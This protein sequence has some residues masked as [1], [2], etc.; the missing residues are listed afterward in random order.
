MNKRVQL[1]VRNAAC[2][3]CRLCSQAE[4]SD[5]CVTADGPNDADVLVVSKNPGGKRYLEMLSDSLEQAGLNWNAV[6]HTGALK[7]R[8]WDIDPNKTDM[9]ACRKYLE[10]ELEYIKPSWVLALGNEALFAATGRSGI[11]NHRGKIYDH[12][13]GAKIFPT[14]SPASVM[15]NPGQQQGFLADLTFF[16]RMVK[17]DSTGSSELPTEIAYV[18]TKEQLKAVCELLALSTTVAVDIETSGHDEF[19]D[20]A[21]LISIA[22]T[23]LTETDDGITRKWVAAIPLGHISSPFRSSWQRVLEILCRYLKR[24]PKVLAH[25]G[26]FDFRWIKQ[27]GVKIDSTFDTMLAAHL[28]N[29]NRE[30]GLKP[31]ARMML[32]AEPWG[33]STKDLDSTPLD[34]VL[35]YNALDT[36]WTMHLYFPLREDLLKNERLA[37]LMSRLMMPASNA[38]VDVEAHGVWLDVERC[39]TQLARY[40]G[41]LMAVEKLLREHVPD[42]HPFITYRA[43]GDVKSDGIN[44]NP[45][46]FLRWWLFDH[47][48]LPVIARGKEKDNGDPGDPSVAEAVM[49]ELKGQHPVIDL[50]IERS[51]YYKA[52]NSFFYPYLEQRRSDGRV[53]TTFKLTG[54]VTGR[55]SSGKADADKVTVSRKFRGVNLQQVPR[56]KDV[57]GVFGAPPGSF[58]VQ[59]D[60]SQVELRIAA[61][62]ANERNMLWHYQSGKDL[63]M[64]M[65]VRLTGKR[66]QDVT[67][68]ERKRAKPVN[69]GF[70][71]AMGWQKFISTAFIQYGV[72]FTDEEAQAARNAFF[73]MW[74]DLLPWHARQ[75]RL[76]HKYKRVVSPLGR[77]RHLPDIDSPNNAVMAEAERQAINSPVQSVASDLALLALVRLHSIFQKREYEAAIIGT[78]HDAIN[79]EVPAA[80]MAEVLPL[81]KSVMENPPTQRLFGYT[82]RVPIVADISV[83]THWG[84][85]IELTPEQVYNWKEQYAKPA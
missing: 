59:A 35:E 13:T 78:V 83:G 21:K 26:K 50:L 64:A 45:S 36:W 32:G 57:R 24:V 20:G 37:R 61:E 84:D 7:C 58:F 75:R 4:G 43:N 54:T 73:D 85:A 11:T 68:E 34:E 5:V 46:N 19:E 62:L 53:H 63:H 10:A 82:M 44:Y 27:F 49:L 60:F 40:Q 28:L 77:I 51:W 23:G 25:N 3:D 80:E 52:V 15:R 71:Y 12:A 65:A 22:F 41:K 29:E 6:M 66:E 72:R 76:A 9:K 55:L 31:L 47:L 38:L 14:I 2:A 81:V 48:G 70:L 33:I 17:G 8:V 39:M 67:K 16:A 42:E 18:K 74:P 56:D 79:F 69:F 1:A 30:K